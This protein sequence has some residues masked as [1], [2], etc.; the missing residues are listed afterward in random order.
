MNDVLAILL[1]IAAGAVLLMI[2]RWD[3][4]RFENKYGKITGADRAWSLG[5]IIFWVVVFYVV[6]LLT[7]E[8][9]PVVISVIAM[10]GLAAGQIGKP[11]SKMKYCTTGMSLGWVPAIIL[12][13]DTLGK[14]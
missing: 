2:V 7:K 11:K 12:F 1:V 8:Y 4:K 10:L 13:F 14:P 9:M 6:L 5:F 3:R